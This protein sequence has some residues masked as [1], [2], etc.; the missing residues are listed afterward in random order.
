MA[1]KLESTKMGALK[2]GKKYVGN[3]YP[4]FI[5]AEI[6][7]NHEGSLFKCSE[8]IKS[9]SAAGVDAVKLQTI[10]AKENYVKKSKS[11]ETFEGNELN[12]HET[13]EMFELAKSLNIEI[14]TTVGDFQTLKWIK[15]LNPCAY[16]VSSGLLTHIPLIEKIA[17]CMQPVLIS[18]GLSDI[19]E[20][21][22]AINIIKSKN[23]H[24]IGIF[25]CTSYYPL[26]TRHAYLN[27]I[28][29]FKNKFN[30]N[31]GFSDHTKG[32][33]ASFLS[34]GLGAVM[35]E[36]HYTFDKSR[37]GFDHGLSLDFNEMKILVEKIRTAEDMIG[38]NLPEYKDFLSDKRL[39]ALR[40]IVAKKKIRK[41]SRFSE[42]NITI[43]R[44]LKNNRGLDPKFYNKLINKI[45][46]QNYEVDDPIKNIT[47]LR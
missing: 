9:A 28:P 5:I 25:Q 2:I 38:K 29:Y 1:K 30:L 44:P 36:K 18:T 22:E 23:N 12:I 19:E 46:K 35:V 24:Q 21:E 16:K 20:V 41:G 4:T 33:D 11:F 8:M 26:E 10:S 6:G 47:K 39:E 3:G 13:K 43:K 42:E 15:D 32:V 37:Q 31:I 34:I 14:F 40:C 7:I 27:R 45:S 17:D